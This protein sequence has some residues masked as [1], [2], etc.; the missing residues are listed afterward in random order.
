MRD[1]NKQILFTPTERF[2]LQYQRR[3]VIESSSDSMVE[4]R[5]HSEQNDW[6][7]L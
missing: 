5:K 1:I 4:I 6:K 7:Y 3:G 2:F